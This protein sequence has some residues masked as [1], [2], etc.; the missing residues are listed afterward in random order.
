MRLDWARTVRNIY[1]S[2]V[3]DLLDGD[4]AGI[5][6]AVHRLKRDIPLPASATETHQLRQSMSTLMER[7]AHM[8]HVRFH[9]NFATAFCGVSPPVV[10]EVEW[11]ESALTT[12]VL[13][14]RSVELFNTWFDDHHALP[15]TLRATQFMHAHFAE[16]FTTQALV[17]AAGCSRTTLMHQFTN[18]FGI[19]PAE[20]VARLRIREGLRRLRASEDSVD[21]AAR[22]VGYQS[23]NKFYA[24]IRKY[25]GLTPSEVRELNNVR[26]EWIL[27]DR[28]CIAR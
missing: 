7:L 28:L 4:P 24:R 1:Q 9:V 14:D 11:M 2:A 13:L 5:S 12:A 27:N 8:A 22:R 18:L 6:A 17:R 25:T 26:F 23:V 10:T 3:G 15:A 20:Y 16:R 19:S 21:D